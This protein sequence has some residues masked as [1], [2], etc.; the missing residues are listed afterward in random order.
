MHL[1]QDLPAV[2]TG[3]QIFFE[4]TGVAQNTD[5]DVIEIV[6]DATGQDP[7]TFELG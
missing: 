4:Q 2:Y 1:C 6:S 3:S 5:Q 7:Q